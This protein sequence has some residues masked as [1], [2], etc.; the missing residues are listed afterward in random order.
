MIM[1]LKGCGIKYTRNH[2]QKQQ[3]PLRRGT[4]MEVKKKSIMSLIYDVLLS[5]QLKIILMIALPSCLVIMLFCHILFTQNERIG[6]VFKSIVIYFI[7]SLNVFQVNYNTS[8]FNL[9]ILLSIITIIIQIEKASFIQPGRLTTSC[10]ATQPS[11][12]ATSPL[13]VT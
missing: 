13:P 11:K 2:Q 10:H 4:S 6:C 12:M 5:I 8:Q 9:I 7:F 1:R 3:L